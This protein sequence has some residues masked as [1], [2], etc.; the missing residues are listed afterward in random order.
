LE[1]AVQLALFARAVGG[2]AFRAAAG[3][4]LGDN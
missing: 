3:F 1:S 2:K 4:R